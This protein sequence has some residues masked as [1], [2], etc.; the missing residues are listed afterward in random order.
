[1]LDSEQG[2][3]ATQLAHVHEEAAGL[4]RFMP[5]PPSEEVDDTP[6][7]ERRADL[8]FDNGIGGFT[9]DGREYVIHLRPG[10][11]TPAPWCNVVANPEFGALVTESGG[12]FTW[13]GNSGEHRLTPWTNDPVSDLPGGAIYVR[14]DETGSIWTPTPQ[15]ADAGS[16][17][18]ISYG[19]GYTRWR[20]IGH[21]LSQDLLVFVAPD[22][23][24]KVMRLRVR[25]HRHRPRRLTVTCYVEWVLGTSP[26]QMRVV[27]RLGTVS[28]ATS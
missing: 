25:N 17:H 26:R 28:V 18:Q 8:L 7:L 3:L 5:G 6:A 19:A 1:M 15:P 9:A 11:T 24:V 14:D 16:A 22:D 2:P 21:G 12:G 23:P 10:D 27:V 4:P 20:S 13:G